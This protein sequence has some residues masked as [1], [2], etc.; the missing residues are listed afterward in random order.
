VLRT[1]LVTSF[2]SNPLATVANTGGRERTR[3]GS[4][5]CSNEHLRTTTDGY[6]SDFKTAAIVH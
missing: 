6:R 5:E 2:A 1:F 4:G 3:G